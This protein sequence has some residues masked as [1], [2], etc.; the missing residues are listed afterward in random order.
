MHSITAMIA[1]LSEIDKKKFLSV[2]KQKN[3]RN[4][5]KNR[6]L[7]LLL[8]GAEST[9]NIDVKLYGRP[10]KGAYHALS[11][12]LSDAL[13]DF[14][15]TKNFEGQA[16][17]DLE[18][19]KYLLAGRV[20][21]EHQQVKLGF[22]M[23][24]KAE[25]KAK[26]FYLYS[27]LNEIYYTQISNAHL[28]PVI[29]VQTIISAFKENKALIHKEE[30]LNLFYAS[31]QEELT[32]SH[33]RASDVIQRNLEQFQISI[34][35]QLTYNSLYRIVKICNRVAH[36]TRDYFAIYEFVETACREIEGYDLVKDRHLNAHIQILYYLAN[37][38]F[39][40]KKFTTAKSY[41]EEMNKAMQLQDRRYYKV[42]F[43]QYLL[44]KNLGFIYTNELQ[45]AIESLDNCNF[46]FYSKEPGFWLDLKL[47]QVVALFLHSDFKAAFHLYKGFYRSDVW[48]AKKNGHLWVIQKNL[49]ELMLLVE[50]DYMDLL[51]SRLQSFRK[52][53]KEHI[54]KHG[55]T[56]V[57]DFVKLISI[58]YFK[59]IDVTK[60][61]FQKEMTKL[62]KI[63]PKE[64]DVFVIGFYAWIQSK[65][66]DTSLYPTFLEVLEEL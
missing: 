41:L 39:R 25:R 16:S 23:L 66:R 35:D 55:A 17:E 44:L 53:H 49:L 12:R 58:V 63:K 59:T 50:L 34:G 10:E 4:D 52:K 29:D 6:E 43:P 13:V 42:F 5:T 38:N 20:F 45:E 14:I 61:G 22:K 40:I 11:K 31:I 27:I 3:K 36:A 28:D 21:F 60:E 1:T 8:D 2:L 33:E 54:E 57:L 30:N 62:L 46:D 47:T 48:Y 26:K 18:T 51:E 32:K 56:R 65:V 9:K 37:F 19:M 7:F 15:A 64:E 24:A